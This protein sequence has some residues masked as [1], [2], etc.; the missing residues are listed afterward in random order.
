M[1][2]TYNASAGSG[3]TTNLVAEYLSICLKDTDKYRNVLAVTFTNNATAE[4]KERILRTLND[5]AFTD[6]SVWDFWKEQPETVQKKLGKTHFIHETTKQLSGLDSD[7]IRDRSE[8]LLEKILAHYPDFAIS[9]IDSFFQRIVRSFAFDLGLNTDFNVEVTLDDYFHQTVDL[10]YQRV[11][12]RSKEGNEL[13]RRVLNLMEQKMEEKG[14][15]SIDYDLL[16]LL[17]DAYFDEQAPANID[18]LKDTDFAKAAKTLDKIWNTNKVIIDQ[19]IDE[20]R[21]IL[22]DSGI[23]EKSFP[24]YGIFDWFKLA[25]AKELKSYTAVDKAIAGGS[26]TKK[27]EPDLTEPER[28]AIIQKKEE[29]EQLYR[30]VLRPCQLVKD[31]LKRFQLLFDLQQIMEELKLQDNTFFLSETGRLIQKEVSDNP[32]PYIYNKVGSRFS[33]FFIDEFQDTSDTQWENMLP[34]LDEA[35]S[36]N[37]NVILFG[38]VKQ[39][40]YRFRNGNPQLFGDL[41]SDGTARRKHFE[42]RTRC[43]KK[44]LDANHRTCKK[45]IHFNNEFFTQ[46]PKLKS[47]PERLKNYVKKDFYGNFYKTV[48]QKTA[49]E[50]DGFVA[51]R[52]CPNNQDVMDD[53]MVAATLEALNDATQNRNY[54]WRDI[55]ILTRKTSMGTT[56]GKALSDNNIPV[57]SADSLVL[58]SNDN[59]NLLISLMKFVATPSDALTRFYIIHL[60]LKRKKESGKLANFIKTIAGEQGKMIPLTEDMSEE[61]RNKA[62]AQNK[63]TEKFH[64]QNNILKFNTLL[65]NDFK[66]SIR[67]EVCANLPLITLIHTL[68]AELKLQKADPYLIALVDM[69][70]DYSENKGNDLHTFLKWWDETGAKKAVTSPENIDA[71]R[72]MTIHKAK[73]KEFPVVIMPVPNKDMTKLTKPKMWKKLD[74]DTMGLPVMQLRKGEE[75]DTIFGIDEYAEE[76]ALTALDEANILYV[77]QTRP[78][79]ALYLILDKKRDKTEEE[80]KKK[81]DKKKEDGAAN[82]FNY[83]LLLEDFINN[84][85]TEFTDKGDWLWYGD[86]THTMP[87]TPKSETVTDDTVPSIPVSGFSQASL[88]PAEIETEQQEIGI[89]V[90]HYFETA[91]RFPKTEAEAEKWPLAEDQPYKE[92]IRAALKSLT[93]NKGLLPYFADGLTVLKEVNLLT[94]DGERRRPDRVVQWNGETV[95]ID[96]KTGEP[97]EESKKKYRKQV[98]EYV[99][100]LN[101]MG[102]PNVRGE[103]L[104][105]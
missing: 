32:V 12:E 41:V 53:F 54:R 80:K 102:F 2:K 45:I 34:L 55:A 59:V 8:I 66:I 30:N 49:K 6:P 50:K 14:Q 46:L 84:N 43:D 74:E 69:V 22:K 95:V 26:F 86:A 25:S 44:L 40:I 57:V 23:P 72:I 71:V 85:S 21:T 79:E 19:L 20:G 62:I 76:C 3:K 18:L 52:F 87:E 83:S 96:F 47:F 16:S 104:Y 88:V 92:E 67:Q 5:F 78:E 77:G 89:A 7:T 37:G 35:I 39:A 28:K 9:T 103:L 13:A 93:R 58:G 81:E 17:K 63:E 33:S 100:I 101:E 73:G 1:F 99:R 27:D 51:V 31:N 38:D 97:T 70:N 82:V 4:M 90:H 11:S 24:Q 29:I 10:L 61:E 56:I 98:D 15:W 42:D 68:M 36:T 60:L 91:D 75:C 64:L 105:L 65:K 48:E 94:A